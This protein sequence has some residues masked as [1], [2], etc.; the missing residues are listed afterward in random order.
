MQIFSV[1]HLQHFPIAR[2][3]VPFHFGFRLPLRQ[4]QRSSSLFLGLISLALMALACWVVF[5]PKADGFTVL[6][7]ILLQCPISFWKI[8]THGGD[9]LMVWFAALLLWFA[10]RRPEAL[11]LVFGWAISGALVQLSKNFI[12]PDAL[13]PMAWFELQ[14]ISLNIP[15]DWMP[16]RNF[17]FPSGHT[18][19]AFVLGFTLSKCSKH[20]SLAFGAALLSVSLGLSRIALFQHFPEDVLAGAILGIASLWPAARIVRQVLRKWP[21]LQTSSTNSLA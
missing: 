21:N 4:M 11:F 7:T 3:H 15:A 17:S 12:F 8:F 1:K 10:R 16:H 13:R 18:A 20:L 14:H 6:N 2:F 9:G 19:T 5:M